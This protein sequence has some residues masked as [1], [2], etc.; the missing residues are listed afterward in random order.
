MNLR[1]TKSPLV[2][3]EP[4]RDMRPAEGAR[5]LITGH[6]ISQHQTSTGSA[7]RLTLSHSGVEYPAAWRAARTV[8]L[9]FSRAA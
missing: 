4:D 5:I 1:D 6:R 9:A 7:C 3:E 2:L 8:A